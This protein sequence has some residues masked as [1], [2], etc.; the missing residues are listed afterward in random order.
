VWT[1]GLERDAV[2][3]VQ[4]RRRGQRDAVVDAA[5]HLGLE[6]AR[7]EG[8]AHVDHDRRPRHAWP[9]AGVLDVPVDGLRAAVELHK[10]ADRAAVLAVQR[11]ALEDSAGQRPAPL[12]LGGRL[13]QHGLEALV[14]EER[15]AEL[16]P[17]P[18]HPLRRLV[19]TSSST[20]TTLGEW[21][22]RMLPVS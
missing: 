11:E 9:G 10:G 5:D 6:A 3:D 7:V 16:Q 15:R 14:L 17:V 8:E 19:A 20:V 1:Q 21:M 18:A 13:L 2:G 12:A 22:L 4:A